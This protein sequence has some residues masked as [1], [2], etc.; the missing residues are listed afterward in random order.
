[1]AKTLIEKLLLHSSGVENVE[2]GDSIRVQPSLIPSSHY[3]INKTIRSFK[4]TGTKK[5]FNKGNIVII[6]NASPVD[7][8]HQSMDTYLLQKFIKDYGI[9]NYFEFGRSGVPGVVLEENGFI[10]PGT[11]LI[12]AEKS[13]NDAGALGCYVIENSY[14]EIALSWATGEQWIKVPKTVEVLLQGSMNAWT[15]GN[16]IALFILKSFNVPV[17]EHFIYEIKGEGLAS[18]P[19][20]ERFNLARVLSDLS[21]K[22]VLFESDQMV[23]EYLAERSERE[24]FFFYSDEGARYL[25][26]LNV[27]LNSIQP[28]LAISADGEEIS[29]HTIT[30]FLQ[31]VED[32]HVDK[33]FMGACGSGR[34][35]DI[36]L[37][38]RT[39]KFSS[40]HPAVQTIVMPGSHR[41]WTDLIAEGLMGILIE[42][43]NEVY[44]ASF[45]RTLAESVG[46]YT[47]NV[48]VLT[49][50]SELFLHAMETNGHNL[51]LGSIMTAFASAVNGM[52]SHPA[53]VTATDHPDH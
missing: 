44:P 51:Y 7:S 47:S 35:E 19:M 16:D 50:S 45:F 25:K 27:N 2:A 22:S 29:Y 6:N 38:V 12:S 11:L 24:G 32:R 9:E 49:S 37:G 30:E 23:L 46:I 15:T 3:S 39:A 18:L 1:M 8:S 21:G 20:H 10:V 53:E 5:L 42:L 40:I 13:F 33:I 14:T 41:I 43:G 36:Q 34:M 26:S 17:E 31:T 28:M 52:V 48:H 4:R